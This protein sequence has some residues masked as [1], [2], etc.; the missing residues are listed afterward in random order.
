MELFAFELAS[1][2]NID[3][4]NCIKPHETRKSLNKLA[5]SWSDWEASH[6]KS[7][8]ANF[9]S[10]LPFLHWR[11]SWTSMTNPDSL[12]YIQHFPPQHGF[13]FP[14]LF[15]RS[16]YEYLHENNQ[17]LPTGMTMN[18]ILSKSWT[19]TAWIIFYGFVL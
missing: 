4:D 10:N 13:S 19:Q 5:L 12:K 8:K 18:K 16:Y 9:V 11:L 7:K 2:C 14:H 3:T 17:H 6:R 15:H 1:K